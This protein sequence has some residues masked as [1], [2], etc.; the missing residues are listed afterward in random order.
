MQFKQCV[1]T[2]SR[3]WWLL[4]GLGSL[5]VLSFGHPTAA[6]SP[7]PNLLNQQVA[8]SRTES[9]E[10]TRPIV[11]QL[12][13]LPLEG[14]EASPEAEPI[15]Q[16]LRE[17]EV[18]LPME[19]SARPRMQHLIERGFDR[20]CC[21][22]THRCGCSACQAKRQ[23]WHAQWKRKLQAKGWGYPERFCDPP[24]GAASRKVWDRQIELGQIERLTLY[25]IDF[26]N[27]PPEL[28]HRL[29]HHGIT[30]L[31]RMGA[32]AE[33]AVQTLKIE[34]DPRHPS[35]DLRR[36]ESVLAWAVE[37]GWELPEEQIVFTR[38]VPYIESQEASSIYQRMINR[39]IGG[40]GAASGAGGAMNVA[41]SAGFSTG[42]GLGGAS[43]GGAG[44]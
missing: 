26:Y 24:F 20:D 16:P 32:D 2:P 33:L 15:Q 28:S 18:E 19:V 25:R 9:I 42:A 1:S 10:P 41:P 13:P 34:S 44:R 8:K 40:Q 12:A 6:Q 36:R 17:V 3:R 4:S 22:D 30:K 31:V 21:G 11:R 43:G 14:G 38:S 23:S 27:D 37:R 5:S 29:N 35:L 7:T 39:S